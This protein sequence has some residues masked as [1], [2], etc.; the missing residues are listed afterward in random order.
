MDH[1]QRTKVANEQ[2]SKLA[3]KIVRS[4][5]QLEDEYY[6]AAGPLSERMMAAAVQAIKKAVPEPFRVVEADVR[7]SIVES[8]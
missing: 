2:D 7:A 6:L 1:E 8:G 5:K 4:L 3:G